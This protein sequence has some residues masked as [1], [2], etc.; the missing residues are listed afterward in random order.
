M[1]IDRH[2]ARGEG[3]ELAGNPLRIGA[4]GYVA[5]EGARDAPSLLLRLDTEPGELPMR[6]RRE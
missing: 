2:V 1:L 6:L 4:G 3:E 5:H